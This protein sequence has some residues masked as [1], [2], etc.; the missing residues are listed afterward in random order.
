MRT[1]ALAFL[2]AFTPQKN[3]AQES[4]LNRIIDSHVSDRSFMGSVT[5]QFTAACVF[6]G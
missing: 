4:P 3:P 6:L 5:E 2:L 1:F